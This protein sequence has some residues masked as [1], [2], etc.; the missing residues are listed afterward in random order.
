MPA[1]YIVCTSCGF[2]NEAPLAKHRC[3]SCG[4]L[5]EEES[6]SASR[7]RA[8]NHRQQPPR[9]RPLWFL[10]AVGVTAVLT[11]AIVM[12][13]PM[14]A[15]PFDFEGYAGMMVAIP[16]WF[17]GGLLV[18]LI[19]PGKTF[20]EPAVA[21]GLVAI[22][23]AFLLFRYQTVKA[24]PGFMYVLM[25]ALGVL[26]ALVGAYVGERLQMGPVDERTSD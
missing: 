1:G 19:S 26:F 10:I 23:T 20:I 11:A 15:P 21:T 12:G 22:P 5:V 2:K 6:P 16:V 13:L 18:G 4:A 9:F 8:P 24:M 14:V 25:S 17:A 3:V 7:S